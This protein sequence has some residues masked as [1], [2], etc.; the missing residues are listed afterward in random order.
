MTRWAALCVGLPGGLVIAG[1]AMWLCASWLGMPPAAV[2]SGLTLAEAAMLADHADAVRLM[3][4]GGDPNAPARVRAGTIDFT[5]HMMSPLEAATRSRQ[6]GI[7][8]LLINS[9]ARITAANYPVLWCSAN[10]LPNNGA[11]IAFLDPQRPA[12]LA[13]IECRDVRIP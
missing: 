10:R 7:L 8:Q 3:S 6:S 9:G 2:G 11:V 4:E 12:G 1:L 5:E 13:P